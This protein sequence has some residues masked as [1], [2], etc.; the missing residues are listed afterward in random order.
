MALTMTLSPGTHIGPYELVA[1]IG[2]GGMGEVYRAR[3]PRLERD[4]AI[5]VLPP[6][7]ARDPDR[8]RRFQQEARA[9][10]ALNHPH[11]MAVFDMGEHEGSPY[12]VCEL[13]EGETLGSRMKAG[14]LPPRRAAEIALEVARGLAAAHDRG[15]VH[16][17]LKPENIFL[18]KNGT[19][20]ILD[21]GLAKLRATPSDEDQPTRTLLGPNTAEGVILGTAGYMS[22]E[23]VRGEQAD[24]RSDLFSLGAVLFEM[25]S[26][27]RPFQGATG[28]EVL[29]AILKEDPPDLRSSARGLIPPALDRIVRHALEKEPDR[30]FQN[31]RDLAFD[32]ENLSHD[33][34]AQSP[35]GAAARK[36]R[37]LAPAL[38]GVLLLAAG[39]GLGALASRAGTVRALTFKRLT[40]GKG[41]VETARFTP[42]SK[43]I[44]YSAR[45]QG[46]APEI[47]AIHPDN[48]QPRSLGIQDASLLAVSP[49]Q[50]LMVM[51]H[52]RLWN[53]VQIGPLARVIPGGGAPRD[54]SGTAQEA[55]WMPDGARWALITATGKALTRV[56]EFPKGHPVHESQ[57]LAAH[58][59]VAPGGDRVAFFETPM[60]ADRVNQITV[61]DAGGRTVVT[62]PTTDFTGLA[63]G[64]DGKEIWYSEA[65]DEGSRLWAAD[66]SGHRRLLLSQAGWLTLWDV[67]PG[68]R[69]LATL[70]QTITG[71]MELSPPDFREKDL[72][73]NE[74]TRGVDFTPDGGSLLISA[75]GRWAATQGR[76]FYLRKTDGSPAVRLGDAA[77][78]RLFPDGRRVLTVSLGDPLKL[79]IVPVGSGEAQ[80]V[81]L[82]GLAFIDGPW[83]L[84][85]GKRAVLGA[86]EAGKSQGF[87]VVDLERGTSRPVGPPD[88]S[89]FLGSNILSPDGKWLLLGLKTGNPLDLN[90]VLIPVDGG[91]SRPIPGFLPGDVSLAWTRDG[92][93]F[94]VFNR[95]GLPTRITRIDLATGNRELV[96]EIIPA[97][98]AGLSGIR[99]IMM[100]PDGRGLAYNYV[101]KLSD[102]FLIEGLR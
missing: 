16:R 71:V 3:D 54:V 15:L 51:P 95:D 8:L 60:L 102:L 70:S 100:A 69:A 18:L 94:L 19:A 41:T 9:A 44:L 67:A 82:K 85:D 56:I 81:A 76:S 99:E 52:S 68:G 37:W 40:F 89:S 25:L 14:P 92:K 5:K 64:P 86:V 88:T 43:E 74:A 59:R 80:E 30:R 49:S 73:W 66:M 72:S 28:V 1:Q 35:I 101:R 58:L 77:A 2:A 45:W 65:G 13:L 21:F 38:G 97:N 48:L 96:R 22:P 79:G 63:W 4:V 78:F 26:G 87:Y 27:E 50:E 55:D 57:F 20:K 83:V 39:A 98:P 61:L 84:P 17:D 32:L 53:N 33:S 6:G 10:G 91:E 7:F 34:G 42:G 75:P 29:N 46:Q 62:I 23:Q 12:L 11:V 24:A 36:R 31:A 47:F 90:P 93:G